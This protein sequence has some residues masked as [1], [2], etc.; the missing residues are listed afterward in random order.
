MTA[1]KGI[2]A[3]I[4]ALL[5][6]F[7]YTAVIV[8]ETS[9]GKDNSLVKAFFYSDRHYF[10][11]MFA[12]FNVFFA[13]SALGAVSSCFLYKLSGKL[14]GMGLAVLVAVSVPMAALPFITDR[15]APKY[16]DVANVFC[17]LLGL[18][19]LTAGGVALIDY[20]QEKNCKY[21]KLVFSGIAVGLAIF[22]CIKGVSFFL[23]GKGWGTGIIGTG[24]NE[25]HLASI[26]VI[27]TVHCFGCAVS[28]IGSALSLYEPALKRAWAM[29]YS[30]V[31]CG[32]FVP[33]FYLAFLTEECINSYC[34]Y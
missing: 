33:L 9:Y 13:F 21:F 16:S 15:Y 1:R 11:C 32:L 27:A 7:L 6:L 2:K 30:A 20:L 26:F 28:L 25:T 3:F 24:K 18:C 4:F 29:R 19:A 34:V 8:N 14:S 12:F 17:G 31:W 10:V 22:L 23:E 5:T